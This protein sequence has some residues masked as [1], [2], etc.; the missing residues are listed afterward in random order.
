MSALSQSHS[1][2]GHAVELSVQEQCLRNADLLQEILEYL[3]P[4]AYCSNLQETR[5]S[6]LWIAQTCKDFT[7]SAVKI[8]WRRLDNILP[9]LR[10]LPAFAMRG[11]T[12]HLTR[13][14]QP[15]EWERFE[16]HAALVKEIIYAPDITSPSIA[17][18]AYVG[19]ALHNSRIL[20]NM[21][22]FTWERNTLGMSPPDLRELLLYVQSPLQRI[23]IKDPFHPDMGNTIISSLP[24]APPHISRLA[25]EGQAPSALFDIT[26]LKHLTHLDLRSM[27]LDD[28]VL[29]QLRSLPLLRSFTADS[30]CV[31]AAMDI[32]AR[33]HDNQ[34]S[35]RYIFRSLT[36]LHLMGDI[37]SPDLAVPSF[38]RNVGAK[39]LQSL[40]LQ[41]DLSVDDSMV[42]VPVGEQHIFPTI[43]ESWSKTL[44][45]LNLWW[46]GSC[47]LKSIC[48]LQASLPF[49]QRLQ[50][51]GHINNLLDPTT[52]EVTSSFEN[53]L[54]L[55]TLI[56][57]CH[58]TECRYN[59]WS[60]QFVALMVE[61]LPRLRELAIPFTPRDSRLEQLR[62]SVRGSK[63][64][65]KLTVNSPSSFPIVHSI[66]AARFLDQ[67][68][69]RL[70]SFDSRGEG[71]FQA[72]EWVL[73]RDLVFAF[74]DVRRSVI[75]ES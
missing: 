36:H 58:S 14:M 42:D 65:R 64:L 37:S 53:L 41:P 30:T 31:N 55:E 46:H 3:S 57:G 39:E 50:V 10:L 45:H 13:A 66:T 23:D 56:W 49:L 12:Y 2:N 71:E 29:R 8:L 75:S 28:T 25:L 63:S 7:P 48:T 74:Q 16:R 27:T 6:L 15:N 61:S 24:L 43:A 17:S 38:L 67:L 73:L 35:R 44:C 33:N 4:V 68:C 11:G 40:T 19:L 21:K 51:F 62:S 34:A 26:P 22:R 1:S 54:A 18:S 32:A 72:E 60:L 9:L 69:P 70:S 47:P 59:R 52:A 5:Q 20:P